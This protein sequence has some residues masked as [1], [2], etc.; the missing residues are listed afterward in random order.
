MHKYTLGKTTRGLISLSEEE[1]RRHIYIVGQTGT[2]KSTLLLNMMQADL[3]SG[4]GFALI[5]PHGDLSKQLA[6]AIPQS[7]ISQTIFF[8]PLA[9]EYVVGFNPLTRPAGLLKST[10]AA[11]L[12][13]AFKR[14]WFDSWG[15][16]LEYI[17]K[18]AILLLLDTNGTSL[19]DIP[20]LLTDDS[21]RDALLRKCKNGGVVGFWRDEFAKY[22][23]KLKA[24]AIAPL[25]NKAGQFRIDPILEAVVG[26]S[27]TID[28]RD[29]MDNR[30]IL[31]LSLSPLMG[32][33]P[34]HLLGAFLTTKFLQAAMT[35][36]DIPEEERE[37]FT[38]YVDEFQNFTSDTFEKIL[39]EARKY[40][41]NLVIAHQYLGQLPDN[42]RQA[43][44]GNVNTFIVFRVGAEDA[45]ALSLQ[46]GITNPEGVT[47]QPNFQCQVKR[48]QDGTPTSSDTVAT[49]PPE[50][51]SGSLSAVLANTRSR[52]ARSRTEVQ[53]A[54]KARHR[55][56][57][58]DIDWSVL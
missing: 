50:L 41:L 51:Q 38:L 18:N 25:Q 2:G 46:L 4:R 45:G 28:L 26:Q 21:F 56:P 11:H 54:L 9:E 32:E 31:V 15:P 49:L 52:F 10:V 53:K 14:V 27:S 17:L 36:T 16:R 8:D 47:D 48:I 29:V 33:E 40:R 1:R 12:L 37:D 39:S 20:R 34:S 13:T 55:K 6:D 3:D 5:D 44:F 35:R 24:E 30:K 19:V 7:R 22:P 23:A 58:K 57:L 42:L 43:V